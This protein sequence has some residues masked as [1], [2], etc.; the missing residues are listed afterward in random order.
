MMGGPLW[1]VG[2]MGVGKTTVAPL[3]AAELDRAWFDSDAIVERDTGETVRE[4]FSESES[5]FR[6]AELRA[7]AGVAESE[8]VVAT[9]GGVV[10]SP[11]GAII[12]GSGYVVWLKAAT[13]TL[14]DR[15]D[16]E[17]RPL[18][19][20]GSNAVLERLAEERDPLYR[21]LADAEI[22][23]DRLSPRDVARKVVEAWKSAAS[24]V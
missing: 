23:T 20:D 21:E 11:A 15:V 24:Q 1:L 8:A 19:D 3:V 22:D 13:A 12:G 17:G 18:L 4:L 5:R 2:L 9:G 7:I 6:E 14:V 10:T 16:T